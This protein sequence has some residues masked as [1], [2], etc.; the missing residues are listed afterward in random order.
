[1]LQVASGE[2]AGSEVV[3]RAGDGAQ[4]S[5]GVEG[6]RAVLANR[7]LAV[8]VGTGGQTHARLSVIERR[9]GRPVV[10]DA[11]SAIAFASGSLDLSAATV[12][13]GDVTFERVEDRALGGGA[14]LRLPFAARDNADLTG[15]LRVT[16]LDDRPALTYQVVLAPGWPQPAQ[17][18]E[19]LSAGGAAVV[20]GEHARAMA[21]AGL[22]R[23][24]RFDGDGQW[25]SLR[26][27]GAKP[28]VAWGD[29]L[30]GSAG[31]GA[32]VLTVL[33]ETRFPA[34]LV[35]RRDA[36]RAAATLG[37]AQP[38]RDPDATTGG[39]AATGTP[40]D[41]PLVAPRVYVELAPTADLREALA[42]YRAVTQ[43]MYPPAALPAWARYQW[44][45]WWTYGSAANEV[46]LRRQIDTIAES[47]ADLGPWHIIV[48][49]GW[50]DVGPGGSGDLGRAAAEKYPAGLR[51]LVDY[52][53]QRG[54]R[55]VLFLSPVYAHDGTAKGE[56]LGLPGWIG[57]HA[58]WFRLLTAPGAQPARYVYDY[59]RPAARDYL[60][61]TVRR[62]VT[63]HGADGIK[64]DGLGD[65]EGH[66]IPF[67]ERRTV[68]PSRWAVTPVMDVYRLVWDSARLAKPDA[69][70]ESGWANPT[71][72]QPY[73]HTF[74]HGDEWTRFDNPY[75]F[76]GLAQ[77]FAYAAVQRGLLG[78]RA[79]VGAPYGGL[80]RPQTREW[81][82]AALALGA[83]VSLA[84][85]LRVLSPQHLAALRG[86]LVHYRPFE[87]VT[88]TGGG[89]HGLAP[90]WSAT[91]LSTPT[92]DMTFVALV[93]RDSAPRRLS[94]ALA[95]VGLSDGPA[96]VALDVESGALSQVAGALTA[97]V[98]EQSLRLFV[99]RRTPGV[100]WTVSSYDAE[101]L[102]TG[103]RLRLRGPAGVDGRLRFYWPG[104]AAPTLSLDGH[105]VA[106]LTPASA[107]G[108]ET[109]SYDS[110]TGVLT[111]G[112]YHRGERVLEVTR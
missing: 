47:F 71:T 83:H 46:G 89:D 111:L 90:D 19:Y 80:E 87:G 92:G 107:A 48:D 50:Q 43:A 3:R 94:V 23:D 38:L 22:V 49:A 2:L 24:A 45:S 104:P 10:H 9:S 61:D 75:P 25:R 33:D 55:V 100:L 101:P 44:G 1:Y 41:G 58:D 110:A 51:A 64:I 27:E 69:F 82:G 18:I 14:R 37:I 30:P 16:L 91:T 57:S 88:R 106:P 60:A 112:Y 66:L 13:A 53:H 76:P 62:V 17:A 108:A 12:P 36:G 79:N 81:L 11:A 31:S 59:A 93:N 63:E 40:D 34:W 56:W 5:Y 65:V 109:F 54:V 32:L 86:L 73:A 52:A 85:D 35:A 84:G 98:P 42:G 28:A 8:L 72:A 21:D 7:P 96:H 95:D 74:R 99:L 97:E 102:S 103:W 20:L 15:E 26:L 77:H 105:A 4:T 29:A 78:Q 68:H 6:D 39:E 67:W 70:V